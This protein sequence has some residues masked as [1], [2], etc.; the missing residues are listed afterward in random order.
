MVTRG[1]LD[2]WFIVND[3]GSFP[4]FDFTD[5]AT[6]FSL[7]MNETYALTSS[8][9]ESNVAVFLALCPPKS[10]DL[11]PDREINDTFTS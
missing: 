3:F 11:I 10:S 5:T 7:K 9:E 6:S 8:D 1:A 4:M 2:T